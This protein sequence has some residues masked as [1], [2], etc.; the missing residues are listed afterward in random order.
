MSSQSDP[1]S[2]HVSDLP[3]SPPSVPSEAPPSPVPVGSMKDLISDARAALEVQIA[4]REATVR[5]QGKPIV[6]KR[7][8]LKKKLSLGSRVIAL[9]ERIN[10]AFPNLLAGDEGTG[11]SQILAILSHVSDF[12][13][14]LVAASTDQPFKSLAEAE[15]WYDDNCSLEDLLNLALVVYSQN[16]GDEGDGLKKYLADLKGVSKKVVGQVSALQ[17]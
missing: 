7:W 5:V 10:E 3:T 1:V 8:G 9:V 4:T 15:D 13:I 16:F 14:E 6:L 12:V 11:A 17:K 2:D